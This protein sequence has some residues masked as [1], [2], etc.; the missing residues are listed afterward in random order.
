MQ[1]QKQPSWCLDVSKM[2]WK[3]NGALTRCQELW[4]NIGVK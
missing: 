1:T 2:V 4:C 3:R